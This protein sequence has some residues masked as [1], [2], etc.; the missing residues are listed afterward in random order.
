MTRYQKC[1]KCRGMEDT[2]KLKLRFYCENC[3]RNNS[4]DE[5]FR[6]A[7]VFS[8]ELFRLEDCL[9]SDYNYM[10]G[11]NSLHP[12]DLYRIGKEK[13]ENSLVG[14]D[15]VKKRLEEAGNTSSDTYKTTVANVKQV[16]E[17]LTKILYYKPKN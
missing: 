12:S 14:E 4:N 11:H 16:Q 17:Q 8:W 7:S 13:L 10:L 6:Y 9:A 3:W 1:I 5:L 2:D 15:A